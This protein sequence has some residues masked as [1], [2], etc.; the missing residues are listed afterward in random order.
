MNTEQ[1]LPDNATAAAA[2]PYFTTFAKDFNKTSAACDSPGDDWTNFT[3][4]DTWKPRPAAARALRALAG[5][6]ET[7]RARVTVDWFKT[8]NGDGAVMYESYSTLTLNVGGKR[9]FVLEGDRA[10]ERLFTRMNHAHIDLAEKAQSIIDIPLKEHWRHSA[11]VTFDD[12]DIEEF[13]ITTP[14]GTGETQG[15]NTTGN[16][17]I[18]VDVELQDWCTLEN[19]PA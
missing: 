15:L 11:W 19:T 16:G 13:D 4:S 9:V 10:A 6:P 3:E 2:R 18:I 17:R 1:P 7:S 8:A 12:G 5:L 14:L